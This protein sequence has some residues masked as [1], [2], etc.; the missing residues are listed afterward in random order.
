METLSGLENFL[1]LDFDI[2]RVK[3][4]YVLLCCLFITSNLKLLR[5][6]QTA[7]HDSN[8]FF[9]HTFMI[10][11]WS[12]LLEDKF[13]QII[14]LFRPRHTSPILSKRISYAS[15]DPSKIETNLAKYPFWFLRSDSKVTTITQGKRLDSKPSRSKDGECMNRH[16]VNL[17]LTLLFHV[18]YNSL[19]TLW[20]NTDHAAT[21]WNWKPRWQHSFSKFYT[22]EIRI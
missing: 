16:S 19:F 11:I 12:D 2:F 4:P 1:H 7:T 6:S 5:A 9:E 10:H 15:K 13:I 3:L 18:K 22:M 14:S 8:E 21:I 20:R 17:S